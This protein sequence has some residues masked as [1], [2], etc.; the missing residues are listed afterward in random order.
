LRCD[1]VTANSLTDALELVEA[2]R[3]SRRHHLGLRVA[4]YRTALDAELARIRTVADPALSPIA[5]K[6][7]TRA[8]PRSHDYSTS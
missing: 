8:R 7:I 2:T 5:R 3:D 6:E 1:T 4:S